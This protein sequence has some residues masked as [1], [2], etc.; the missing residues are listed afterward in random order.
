MEEGTKGRTF[1]LRRKGLPLATASIDGHLHAWTQETYGHAR[2][3]TDTKADARTRTRTLTWTHGRTLY[4]HTGT[5]DS[6]DGRLK[7][8]FDLFTVFL[9]SFSLK[10]LR[11]LKLFLKLLHPFKTF[12][13]IHPF[14][15]SSIQNFFIHSESIYVSMIARR[16]HKAYA[17]THCSRTLARDPST[18]SMIGIARSN[19]SEAFN[20]MCGPGGPQR[21]S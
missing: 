12:S 20:V 16:T 11:L 21:F 13:S 6:T 7:I 5:R 8:I 9:K 15:N 17:L 3:R 14:I 1:K 10:L 4:V 18:Q 2:G 19:A